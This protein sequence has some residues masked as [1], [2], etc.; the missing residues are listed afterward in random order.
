MRLAYQGEAGFSDCPPGYTPSAD[1]PAA[2]RVATIRQLGPAVAVRPPSAASS[3]NWSPPAER[4]P[5]PR[6]LAPLTAGNSRAWTRPQAQLDGAPP[7]WDDRW[8]TAWA[9]A[10]AIAAEASAGPCPDGPANARL[11]G[12]VTVHACRSSSSEARFGL[13]PRLAVSFPTGTWPAFH[14]GSNTADR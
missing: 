6:P 1:T 2:P 13:T 11:S 4:G 5:Y 12:E 3:V 8:E 9:N 14:H 10:A 7:S